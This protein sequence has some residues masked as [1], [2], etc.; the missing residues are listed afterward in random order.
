MSSGKKSFMAYHCDRVVHTGIDVNM[1]GVNMM[2]VTVSD[3]YAV[4]SI[5]PMT[6]IDLTRSKRNP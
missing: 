5:V 4:R 3:I 1:G 6:V 2:D